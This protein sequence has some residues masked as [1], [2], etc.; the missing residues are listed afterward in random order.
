MKKFLTM[1]LLIGFVGF[2]IVP[3]M[4]NIISKEA[5]EMAEEV[6]AENRFASVE[7]V[8]V[9]PC[10][11]RIQK[12][13]VSGVAFEDLKFKTLTNVEDEIVSFNIFWQD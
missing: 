13:T 1:V 5:I 9:M 4:D 2:Y 10:V 3:D 12:S 7:I 11:Y 6:K 8:R